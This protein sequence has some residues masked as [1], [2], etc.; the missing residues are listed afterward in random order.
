MQHRLG[1]QVRLGRP[2]LRGLAQHLLPDHDHEHQDELGLAGQEQQEQV[3]VR[4]EAEHLAGDHPGDLEDRRDIEGGHRACLVREPGGQPAIQ[5]DPLLFQW[6]RLLD[7]LGRAGQGRLVRRP[8]VRA[9]GQVSVLGDQVILDLGA[10]DEDGLRILIGVHGSPVGGA[11]EHLLAEQDDEDQQQLGYVPEE[12]QEGVG[13][14]IEAQHRPGGEHHPGHRHDQADVHRPHRPDPGRDPGGQPLVDP[15]ALVSPGRIGVAVSVRPRVTGLRI[16]AHQ[17]GSPSPS[18]RSAG[19]VPAAC[20][21]YRSTRRSGRPGGKPVNG[22]LSGN[23]AS[24]NG[25]VCPAAGSCSAAGRGPDRAS[26]PGR[27][28]WRPSVPGVFT[29]SG[30]MTRMTR[31]SGPTGAS[32][33]VPR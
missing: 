14:G 7:S 11:A 27:R 28:Y 3:R 18:G 29:L 1:I 9:A 4:I 25:R 30:E 31:P 16:E 33:S 26:R 17:Q 15:G 24:R 32:K 5:A 21:S 8:Q 13:I 19:A 20:S 12:E 22:G 10:V 6:R 2:L 23:G